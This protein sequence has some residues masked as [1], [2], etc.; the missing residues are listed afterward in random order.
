MWLL[1]IEKQDLNLPCT[2]ST[3]LNPARGCVVVV[4]GITVGS[5][6]LRYYS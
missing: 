3:V 2:E 1:G 5:H 6:C 4:L